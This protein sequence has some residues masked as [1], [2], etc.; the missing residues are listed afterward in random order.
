M[1]EG[2]YPI[3]IFRAAGLEEEQI[4]WLDRIFRFTNHLPY[5][6][7]DTNPD[8]GRIQLSRR[9][10]SFTTSVVI[11][12]GD[13]NQYNVY[14]DSFHEVP[15]YVYDRLSCPHAEYMRILTMS[16]EQF[17][18]FMTR[19]RADMEAQHMHDMPYP[20]P[21]DLFDDYNCEC[22]A[23]GRPLSGISTMIRGLQIIFPNHR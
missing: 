15:S 11:E 10:G 23:A 12:A 7:V 5:I 18:A 4:Q 20:E 19:L 16:Q 13:N 21:G 14:W 22:I 6:P 9:T 17:D 3:S 8:D 2:L 1:P